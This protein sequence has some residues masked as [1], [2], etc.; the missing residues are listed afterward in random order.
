MDFKRAKIVACKPRPNYR[1][2]ICFSDKWIENNHREH[3]EEYPSNERQRVLW[4]A[5][6]RTAFQWIEMAS[7][8]FLKVKGL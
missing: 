8:L 2:W 5:V 1:V 3:R 6:L 4:S 7:S